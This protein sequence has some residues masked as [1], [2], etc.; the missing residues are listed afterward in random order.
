MTAG[1]KRIAKENDSIY[2]INILGKG[3]TQQINGDG[4]SI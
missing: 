1:F 2:I 4:G 3:L